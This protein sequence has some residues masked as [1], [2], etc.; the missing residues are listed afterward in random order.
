MP[1]IKA[2]GYWNVKLPQQEIKFSFS[3]QTLLDLSEKLTPPEKSKFM[4]ALWNAL[5]SPTKPGDVKGITKAINITQNEIT[6][7]LG[8][9][10]L[11][12]TLW[13]DSVYT[14]QEFYK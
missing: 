3:Y 9:F 12:G 1:Q 4:E 5:C 11:K 6:I 7:S 13:P 14:I 2:Y 8:N 10:K